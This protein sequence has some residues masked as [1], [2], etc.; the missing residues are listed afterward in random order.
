MIV[1]VR[2][3]R[4]PS[5]MNRAS[6][7]P[8]KKTPVQ[9]MQSQMTALLLPGTEQREVNFPDGLLGLPHCQ[10]F[11]LSAYQP[12]DGSTSPFFLLQCQDEDLSFPLIEPRLFLAD[13]RFHVA[14]EV[15][16]YLKANSTEEL[17]TLAI[18]T[19]RD[20]MENITMN[21]QG[22]L[23]MNF[24]AGLGVQFILEHFPV[25]YPL[26]VP[27]KETQAAAK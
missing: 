17:S 3:R 2:K 5:R 19:V 9:D 16:S 26:F 7:P 21:L 23:V 13:Y 10:H 14:P 12:G 24:N 6:A 8:P 15:L 27:E 25:R 18:V 22:P 4:S 11:V 1:S 20:Q